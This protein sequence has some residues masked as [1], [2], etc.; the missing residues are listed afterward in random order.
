MNMDLF[1]REYGQGESII[2]L[3]GWLGMSDHW[4]SIGKFLSNQ[5]YNVIIPDLPNHGKSFHTQEFSYKEMAEIMNCF[6]KG[7]ELVRPILI[8]HSMGGK[9]GME[10]INQEP[11]Y[12]KSLILVDIHFKDYNDPNHHSELTKQIR[13]INPSTFSSLKDI[14]H[15][16]QEKDIDKGWIALIIKNLH[17]K[18]SRPCW[19]SNLPMLAHETDKVMQEVGIITNNIP[20]LLLR[21]EN[22]DYVSDNDIDS[23]RNVYKNLEEVKI[24]NSG[25]W[26]HAD[27]PTQFLSS[28]V[29]YLSLLP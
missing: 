15:Y 21:G 5:D 8:G 11:D 12:F 23:L 29:N 2:I 4:L 10:M 13:E 14:L 18:N 16:L 25:H 24:K 20:T 22:S 3:H 26:V 17:I 7:K 19:K 28:V 6:C 1:F 27:N 9:I